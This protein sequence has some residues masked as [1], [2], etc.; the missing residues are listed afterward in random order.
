MEINGAG[1]LG[2]LCLGKVL[3]GGEK[4]WLSPPSGFAVDQT[5]AC[6]GPLLGVCPI[7]YHALNVKFWLEFE[8]KCI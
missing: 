7:P 6:C 1:H 5:G 4:G 2:K 8:E 3:S